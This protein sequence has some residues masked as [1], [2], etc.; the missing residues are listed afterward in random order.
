MSERCTCARLCTA[1][2]TH[3]GFA[4]PYQ[5]SR[6]AFSTVR[7][8]NQIPAESVLEKTGLGAC[9]S[10]RIGRYVRV[11]LPHQGLRWLAR[12][13]SVTDDVLASR[14]AWFAGEPY[15]VRRRWGC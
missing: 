15:P 2:H 8:G 11:E 10:V 7:L 13:L 6:A 1:M 4:R 12:R 9:L 14:A 5:R 3:S